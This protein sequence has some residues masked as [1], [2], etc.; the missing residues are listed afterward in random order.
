MRN[1]SDPHA[2]CYVSGRVSVLETYLLNKEFFKRLLSCEG[3]EGLHPFIRESPVG[4]YFR[5]IEDLYDLERRLD[6]YYA[7]R[8]MDIRESSPTS[9]LCDLVQTRYDFFNG[10]GYIK[11]KLLGIPYEPRPLGTLSDDEWENLWEGERTSLPRIFQEAVLLV[12]E[13]IQ[14]GMDAGVAIDSIFDNAYLRFL[15]EVARPLGRRLITDFIHEYQSV[16]GVE[17]VWRILLSGREPEPV[18]PL[19]LRGMSDRLSE[20]IRSPLEEWPTILREILSPSV[21]ERIF[22]GSPQEGIKRYV[23]MTDDYLLNRIKDARYTPF[24]PERVFGYL[25][26]LEREVMNLRLT[27]GGKMNRIHPVLVEERLRETYA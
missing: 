23:R 3:V 27:V 8:L 1:V 16:K 11:K 6:E 5:T 17:M 15:P 22:Q 14:R 18:L 20:L 9:L 12:K 2:W 13:E 25:I 7:A 24:G 21:V 10:K 26:G 4:E 19:L